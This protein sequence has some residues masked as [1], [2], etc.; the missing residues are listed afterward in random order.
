MLWE[1]TQSFW[2]KK[3]YWPG[4]LLSFCNR[5]IDENVSI[6]ATTGGVL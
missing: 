3:N 6:E 4:I 1:L 2:D 5:V